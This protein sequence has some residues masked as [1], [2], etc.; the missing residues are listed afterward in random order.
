MICQ[1]DLEKIKDNAGLNNWWVIQGLWVFNAMPQM[2]RAEARRGILLKLLSQRKTRNA[3]SHPRQGYLLP[4]EIS[5]RLQ[6]F[7]ICRSAVRGSSA[8][9]AESSLAA[10]SPGVQKFVEE[11]DAPRAAMYGKT[12]VRRSQGTKEIQP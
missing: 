8:L 2:K 11:L 1:Q 5:W 3:T 4:S 10:L 6:L 12:F 9:G 7:R